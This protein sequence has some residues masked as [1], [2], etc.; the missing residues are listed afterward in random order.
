MINRGSI[1]KLNVPFVT[2]WTAQDITKFDNKLYFGTVG[3]HGNQCANDII[4]NSDLVVALGFRFT[5]KAIN[6]NFGLKENIQRIEFR[7]EYFENQLMLNDFV[8]SC[9]VIVHLAAVNRHQDP[10]VIYDTN[11]K[12]VKQ[13]LDCLERTNSSP[14]IIMSSSTQEERNNSYGKSKKEGRKIQT[15][16]IWV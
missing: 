10:Q 4:N 14:H 9:D 13:L 11:I 8:S 2:S 7:D 5:P 16:D 1:R 3:R 6:E 12:L 15:N